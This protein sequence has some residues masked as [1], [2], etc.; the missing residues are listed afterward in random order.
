MN[1]LQYG[2]Q[3]SGTNF[4]ESLLKKNYNVHFLNSD[5]DRSSPLQKHCRLYHDKNIIAHPSYRNDIQINSYQ[6]FSG[7]FEIEPEYYLVISKDPYSWYL[8][9]KNWA[10]KCD[11]PKLDHHY[12]EEYNLFY[13]TFIEL[14]EQSNKFIFVR[15]IDL[16]KNEEAVLKMLKEKMG[17][18]KKL[19]ANIVFKT[20]KKVAQ[21]KTFS[22]SKKNY[23][24]NKTYLQDYSKTELQTLNKHLDKSVITALGY[25]TV[26]DKVLF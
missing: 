13:K 26:D 10:E 20:P 17:I 22:K 21:S 14:S 11:W 1:I 15:Y 5:E 24:L 4:L 18:K 16:L 9:Y 7:L 19:L 23:Y 25:E 3:R 8:S 2:L 12:I 6:E